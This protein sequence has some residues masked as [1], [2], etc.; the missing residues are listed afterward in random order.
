MPNAVELLVSS[1]S[2]KGLS[3]FRVLI[4]KLFLRFCGQTE[5]SDDDWDAPTAQESVNLSVDESKA[6]Q[7]NWRESHCYCLLCLSYLPQFDQPEFKK[8]FLQFP[9]LP[10]FEVVVLKYISLTICKYKPG[11][12]LNVCIEVLGP[13]IYFQKSHHWYIWDVSTHAWIRIVLT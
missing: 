8:T 13:R 12:M 11:W 4:V 10:T 2:D 3:T 9:L 6:K 5:Q 1:F 7:K